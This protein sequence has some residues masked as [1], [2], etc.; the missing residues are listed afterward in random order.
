MRLDAEEEHY[1]EFLQAAISITRQVL[2]LF[3]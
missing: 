2:R 1:Q 3:R